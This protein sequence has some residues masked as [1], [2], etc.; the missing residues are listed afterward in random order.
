MPNKY[1]VLCGNRNNSVSYYTFPKN[2]ELCKQWLL[3]CGIGENIL[4]TATKLCSNHFEKN[5]IIFKAKGSV[6]KLNAV[7]CIKK[8]RLQV[9]MNDTRLADE[10]ADDITSTDNQSS[11]NIT[12]EENGSLFESCIIKMEHEV[13][14]S[15]EE[16]KDNRILIHNSDSNNVSL[17][18]TSSAVSWPSTPS[19]S[20]HIECFQTPRKVVHALRYVGDIET[21]QLLTP[22]KAKMA[23]DVA[24]RTIQNLRKKIKIL[25]Q[26]QRRL[27]ARITTMEGLIKHLK[28]KSKKKN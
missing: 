18:E 23:L 20:G 13:V 11:N 10:T 27:V 21:S 1:C 19:N 17:K 14:S 28:N 25:Q 3:F 5:D 12:L 7:P 6:V 8:R 9:D 2:K 4:N 16:T 15:P 26:S 24:K 22:K